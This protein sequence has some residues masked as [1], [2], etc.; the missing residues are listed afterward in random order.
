MS[1]SGVKG[2]RYQYELQGNFSWTEYLKD[3]NAIP[4][5][6][7]CFKQAKEPPQND[8]RVGMKLEAVDP[9]NL[10]SIC[11]ATV[12]ATQGSRVRLRLDGS[13]NSNDFW[14]LVDSADLHPIGYCK[15]KGGLLQ[16]PLGF[17][18]NQSCWPSFLKKALSGAEIASDKCFKK[19]PPGPKTNEF[20]IGQ[21]L[22]AVDRKNTQLICPATVG[23]I[24]GDQIHVTF[25]GWRGAF[26]YWCRYDCR[27]I[28]RVR[29]CA[30][31][32]HPLQ[33]PGKK[34]LP[35][36]KINKLM[37]QPELLQTSSPAAEMNNSQPQTMPTS[38]T[39]SPDK[40]QLSPREAASP[41]ITV[42][43]PDTSSTPSSAA[44]CVYVNSSCNCGMYL[45]PRRVSGMSPQYGPGSIVRV[46]RE[47]VQACI[48][49]ATQERT[50]FNMI[51]EGNG[52]VVVTANHGNKTNTKRVISV[53]KVSSFWSFL[54]RLTEDLG[55]CENFFSSQPVKSSC[56]KCSKSKTAD[57]NQFEF[58]TSASRRRWST[59]SGDSTKTSKPPK[60]ARRFSTY[61]AEASSTTEDNH[62]VIR[63]RKASGDVN[64]WTIEEVISFL[65]DTDTNL[66][67]HAELFRKHEIDG[68]ALLLLNSEMMM[69]YM[70]LKLGPVLKL[71]NII[72]K[73]KKGLPLK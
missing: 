60:Q 73:L 44:V 34:G 7:H 30:D 29:W 8:F 56:P 42:S 4:A 67:Q 49:C 59:E 33:P 66:G 65:A 19:E 51:K 72:E 15:N 2:S 28:F 25:D 52:K 32:G 48:D 62:T 68:K 13:D 26:D 9:R 38:P 71:C 24:N 3:E 10:T 45:N 64:D 35:Q 17:R 69:K 37:K 31:S 12:V 43:E 57:E 39:V 46:L 6:D 70:G 41:V 5:P 53:E 55:C 20:K 63:S 14:R 40:Q 16:P 11:V 22:E 61:E 27:D 21:K 1:G 23:A 47:V 36:Y 58:P 18:M 50:V 54:E